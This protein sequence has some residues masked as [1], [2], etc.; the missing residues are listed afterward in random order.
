MKACFCCGQEETELNDRN[1]IDSGH[2]VTNKVEFRSCKNEC[3]TFFLFG[4]VFTTSHYNLKTWT[5]ELFD[6]KFINAILFQMA[7]SS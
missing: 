7:D 4:A 5:L 2:D 1:K 6:K 3:E